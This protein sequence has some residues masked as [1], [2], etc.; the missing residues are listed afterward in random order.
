MRENADQKNSKYGHIPRSAY[1]LKQLN[2][3]TK[4]VIHEGK[5]SEIQL[6]KSL[7]SLSSTFFLPMVFYPFFMVKM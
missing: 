4:L 2:S 6:A 5:S 3:A 1:P 7:Y